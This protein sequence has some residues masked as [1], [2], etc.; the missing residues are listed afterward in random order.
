LKGK[1]KFSL[2]IMLTLAISLFAGVCFVG[3]QPNKTNKELP[4]HAVATINGKEY[5][6]KLDGDVILSVEKVAVDEN[7]LFIKQTNN[8]TGYYNTQ[9]GVDHRFYGRMKDIFPYGN[10]TVDQIKADFV[11]GYPIHFINA[12][13]K[14]EQVNAE[15]DIVDGTN[16]YI[17]N[18]LEITQD[19]AKQKFNEG[20]KVCYVKNKTYY[21][22]QSFED[23]TNN[24]G[25]AFYVINEV[26]EVPIYFKDIIQ[27]G[28]KQVV[29]D[30]QFVM[31]NNKKVGNQYLNNL[32][33]SDAVI[34]SLGQY[35]LN[36]DKVTFA[37]ATLNEADDTNDE[38]AKK[39]DQAYAQLTFL[40]VNLTH[41]G[42]VV[43][44]ISLRN[45]TSADGN[46]FFDFMYMIREGV[47]DESGKEIDVEGHYVLT[48]TYIKGGVEYTTDFD[49]YL[50]CESTYT[51]T[52]TVDGQKYFS[53]PTLGWVNAGEFK[54]I[55]AEND[56]YVHYNEG[57]D[58]I[59]ITTNTISYPTITYDYTKY[60]MSYELVANRSVT[61]YSLNYNVKPNTDVEMI[62]NVTGAN[63]YQIPFELTNYNEDLKLVTVVFTEHGNYNFAF[64]Y[65][66]T[67]ADSALAPTM[68][69]LKIDNKRLSIHG[70]DLN[71][72]KQGFT[73]AKFNKFNFATNTNAKVNLIVPNGYL[74]TENEENAEQFKNKALGFMYTTRQINN[75]RIGEVV[76]SNEKDRTEETL[77]NFNLTSKIDADTVGYKSLTEV[78]NTYA[79]KIIDMNNYNNLDSDNSKQEDLNAFEFVKTNQGSIWIS[80]TDK[81]L[82]TREGTETNPAVISTNSSFYFYSRNG[83]N[84]DSLVQK[85]EHDN[86]TGTAALPYNNQTSFNKVGY[87]L[88]FIKVDPKADTNTATGTTDDFWQIYAFQ[89]MSDT[90]D[91]EV[92]TTG[93]VDNSKN[94]V[95]VGAGKYTKENVTI[96][97][98]EPETFESKIVG[99]YYRVLN[100]N[101]TRDELL[102]TG[103]T[104]LKKNKE[105]NKTQVLGADVEYNS[106]AKY[107]IKLERA[108]KSAT[109]KMFTIDRQP[110][111]GVTPYAVKARATKNAVYYE[112]AYKG[113]NPIVVSNSITNSFAT[114]GWNKKESGAQITCKYSYTP[115]VAD[116]SVEQK[117]VS[118]NKFSFIPTKYKLGET[119]NNCDLEE[120]QSMAN[121]GYD[122]VLMG[123]GIYVFT[124]TDEAG[125]A[126]KYMLVIDQT[127]AYLQVATWNE[128]D[129]EY[130]WG[131]ILPNGSYKLFGDD[132][133][134]RTGSHKA[135]ALNFVDV[136]NELYGTNGI[137]NSIL[138]NNLSSYEEDGIYYY[139]G[140]GGASINTLK[141]LFAN[142]SGANYL[143]VANKQIVA[144]I[145]KDSDAEDKEN[146][147]YYPSLE[148]EIIFDSMTL[149]GATSLYRYLY[150]VGDNTT[151]SA[152]H[153]E[154][155]NS[156]S[157]VK[158]EINKDNSLGMVYYSNDAFELEVVPTNGDDRE[159]IKRLRT[160]S[161]SEYYSGLGSLQDGAH[162]TKDKY[163]GF[164]WLVGK[165]QFTVTNLEYQ[166][167]E[168]NVEVF[169]TA[170]STKY[171]YHKNGN[172]VKLIIEGDAQTGVEIKTI[173]G[174][175]RGFF[176]FKTNY[177]YTTK[178]GLYVVTRYYRDNPDEITGVDYG[179]DTYSINYYFIVDRNG[180][181]DVTN[182][183]G[184]N[185]SVGLLNDKTR[186][187]RE[188]LSIISTATKD[189]N[190][191]VDGDGNFTGPKDINEKYY[192]YFQTNRVPAVLNIPT[193]KYFDG[194]NS[195]N[196]YFAG[197]LRI[198][199]YFIDTNAQ[200]N[201][202]KRDAQY[203]I[204]E[205][206]TILSADERF[207]NIDFKQYLQNKE[208]NEF[209]S[210]FI[211]NDTY[212]KNWLH[213][214]GRY[215]VIIEDNVETTL[216]QN[217]KIIGFDI[218]EEQYP[219]AEVK[220]GS[221]SN[222]DGSVKYEEMTK[223]VPTG[224]NGEYKVL[225]NQEFIR[226]ELPKLD[227]EGI[228]A[229]VDDEYIYVKQNWNN[230]G[231]KDY[232]KTE[233]GITTTAK[234]L[235]TDALKE[236]KYVYLETYL[237]EKHELD[238]LD[239]E[240]DSNGV[241][242]DYLSM[243]LYYTIT[244]R[245]EIRKAVNE[246]VL[247]ECYVYYTYDAEGKATKNYY[248][249]STYV[250]IIDRLAPTENVESLRSQDTLI[251][252]QIVDSKFEADYYA[253][254]SKI[255]FTY[256]Y[257][258][259][260]NKGKKLSD[261]Y[262][263]RVTE[264]TPYKINDVAEVYYSKINDITNLSLD[265][266]KVSTSG[267]S[268]V[269]GL[270]SE[271]TFKNITGGTDGYYQMLELDNAGN[272]TQYVIYYSTNSQENLNIPVTYKSTTG[273]DKDLNLGDPATNGTTI[274]LYTIQTGASNNPEGDY[275]FHITLKDN[276][277]ADW[278]GLNFATNFASEYSGVNSIANKIINAI[279]D[280]TGNYE[281]KILSRSGHIYSLGIGVYSETDKVPLKV[282]NLIEN[283]NGRYFINLRGANVATETNVFYATKIVVVENIEGST[284]LI[285]KQYICRIENGQY[286]YYCDNTLIPDAMVICSE[287]NATYKITAYDVFGEAYPTRFNTFGKEFYSIEFADFGKAYQVEGETR[288]YAYSD[289]TISYDG[290][291]KIDY[292]DIEVYVDG[293][294]K[295]GVDKES[296]VVIDNKNNKVIIKKIYD[297]EEKIYGVINV[298]LLFREKDEVGVVDRKY[299][300][301]IDTTTKPVKLKDYTTNDEKELTLFDNINL[302]DSQVLKDYAPE[303]TSSGIMNL[304]WARE[305]KENYLYSYQL[306]ELKKD[307]N[308]E[309]GVVYLVELDNEK[310]VYVIN[311]Q[312]DSLGRYWF[313]I[314]VLTPDGEVIGNKVYAFEV[315][316]NNNNLYYV[317]DEEGQAI[318]PNSTF[319][320]D[321]ILDYEFVGDRFVKDSLPLTSMPLYITNQELEIVL[322]ENVTAKSMVATLAD[323][324]SLILYEID[325]TTYQVYFAVLQVKKVNSL[326]KTEN[327]NGEIK[328]GEK[329][330]ETLV[331]QNNISYIINAERKIASDKIFAKN[332]LLLDVK[333]NGETVKTVEY[334]EN[335]NFDILG[336]GEYTFEIRDLAGNVHQFECG[337]TEI[338]LLIL[339]EVAITLNDQIPVENAYYN[340]EVSLKVYAATK[341]VVG[342]INVIA[343]R[344][345]VDYQVG[346]ANPYIFSD[347]GT[348]VVNIKAEFKNEEGNVISL[349]KSITF[350]IINA[351]EV[352]TAIDLTNLK[353]HTITKVTN[354]NGVDV[355]G[356]FMHMIN[357]KGNAM[358]IKYD[359]IMEEENA[360]ALQVSAGK[361]KFTIEYEVNDGIYPTRNLQIQF[362]LNN[363]KPVINCSLG[364]GEST[365]EEFSISFNPGIIYEQIGDSYI[366]INDEI[367]YIINAESAT[368]LVTIVRSFE[369]HGAGD[370]Y[371]KVTGTSGTVWE[372]FKVEIK[373]PLN[374][375]AI[376]IIVVVSVVV[377]A[378]VVTIIVLR[379]K[380]R[381][382]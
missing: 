239:R 373:E 163:I 367:V 156:N 133:K 111:S 327:I 183:I 260:Y 114:L 116:T 177:D 31:L 362:T 112:V 317:K 234:G 295:D 339:R 26:G 126:T 297:E 382:R 250:I 303:K 322:T 7:G 376:I 358:L 193:G 357:N 269:G 106:F 344:N 381:I 147:N 278:Q 245:Y 189:F 313:V 115:I 240:T 157:F 350:S 263:F 107:L 179:D 299:D 155:R 81:I 69:R 121:V 32:G 19:Q 226:V 247:S 238:K 37:T 33:D 334:K 252:N 181:H 293:V 270:T 23:I 316:E 29:E 87:Y 46:P 258:D 206:N 352:R 314:N 341:Y 261:I 190:F 61:S 28:K 77:Q 235:E 90:I 43:P 377:I 175:Q 52:K 27:E 42:K 3:L 132:I 159:N 259:Y 300:I 154:P 54:E 5:S 216:K 120:L 266:P 182:E 136:D 180:I 88:V 70:S 273:E 86:I 73:S 280:R 356:A 360:K 95:D 85:D 125:N 84:N 298:I 97:W 336:N 204:F 343:T 287:A 130:V 59:N 78:L 161:D 208:S 272:M 217:K 67:G 30:G 167:Y 265:L 275:F 91:I 187:E 214:Q 359:E 291:F 41:N 17:A 60:Q 188:K 15:T 104:I 108:G 221:Q 257:D 375:S 294:K 140:D 378:V 39:K 292:S 96:S 312:S 231:E 45:I 82:E 365:K 142:Y 173:E 105:T 227:K 152:T 366:Y 101:A 281:L 296:F 251:K 131:E 89:Y 109:Y 72:S 186:I 244:I 47:K 323:E 354:P 207:F 220:I 255:Y 264:N 100:K 129:S 213:L 117:F 16:Y 171:F 176:L 246:D 288:Y 36:G 146:S 184:N 318:N 202:N 123:Q 212:G 103:E 164:T 277:F 55:N 124:I 363:E 289:T 172:P 346:K 35:V 330:F 232:I 342:S 158:I 128:T 320:Q 333:Y 332:T 205:K 321:D 8:G 325:A 372:S 304:T 196:G 302:E 153:M 306:F 139:R 282:E 66:Y 370:Y 62:V 274:N 228:L 224:T 222:E 2:K 99:K 353:Q 345:G 315:L 371:I 166:F 253:E 168:L 150:I 201:P 308:L 79:T 178:A 248:Y 347:Y 6:A 256:Q 290:I 151:Y 138:N 38:K 209:I 301:T 1:L 137:I 324:Q 48:T 198:S 94:N 215:V 76:I 13:N 326:V 119:I 348:Y 309:T 57:I 65:L 310:T 249:Y 134:Y 355:T 160:G 18:V 50:V 218:I 127:E 22:V 4:A 349:T 75:A 34:I 283:H 243:P 286:N 254:T 149:K 64:K 12:E 340:G 185:I 118:T 192:V 271:S 319:K 241:I 145:N 170:D 351:D 24:A 211:A 98:K 307:A 53:A 63:N 165:D 68:D 225:T 92:K 40:N 364:I 223:V 237:H 135:I 374:A 233:Y 113:N 144:Y 143:T 361:L 9:D 80:N 338:S 93:N 51:R 379:R 337:E 284:E 102:L 369:E 210:K 230:A 268:I 200:I 49:F 242:L 311:T 14:F 368:D 305:D 236:K 25:C 162:A 71:Y 44:D 110:I 331:N 191:D 174:K 229:Q 262:A 219:Q 199:V 169:N 141:N 380:M 21:N 267:F 328:L 335:I 11:A 56:G 10:A 20:N 83:I 276:N 197:Q 74:Q 329:V 195:S 58:G 203:K 148:K 285:T 279:K 122:S 194:T